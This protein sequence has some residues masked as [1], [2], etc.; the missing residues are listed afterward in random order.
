MKLD[1]IKPISCYKGFKKNQKISKQS[2]AGKRKQVTMIPQ[3]FEI[4]RCLECGESWR[5]Y[6][7]I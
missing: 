7:F 6:G 2:I 5:S 3:E 1:L 4:I